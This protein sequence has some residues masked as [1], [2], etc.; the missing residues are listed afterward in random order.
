[1]NQFDYVSRFKRSIL[2]KRLGILLIFSS[3][4]PIVAYEDTI[5]WW[6]GVGLMVIGLLITTQYKC[7]ACG[8]HFDIRIWASTL[9]YCSNCSTKLRD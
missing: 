7:P 3:I 9:S 8:K 2:Y 6:F 1:M 5:F 4:W